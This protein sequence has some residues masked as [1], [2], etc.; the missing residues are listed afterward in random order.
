[1][2]WDCGF[3][4]EKGVESFGEV[5]RDWA[6]GGIQILEDVRLVCFVCWLVGVC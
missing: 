6:V 4:W 2:V 1:M 3:V 5:C